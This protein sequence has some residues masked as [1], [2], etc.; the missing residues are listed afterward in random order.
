MCIGHDFKQG[1]LEPGWRKNFIN[2]VLWV[3]VSMYLIVAGV[4]TNCKEKPF[5]YTEYLGPNYRQ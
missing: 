2:W 4:I 3:G 5:D 1:P